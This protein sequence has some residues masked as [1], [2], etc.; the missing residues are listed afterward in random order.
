[1]DIKAESI[2]SYAVF[3]KDN[4]TCRMCSTKVQKVNIYANDA[5]ELDHIIPISKGGTHTL[6]NVQT[7]CRQCNQ[8]KSDKMPDDLDLINYIK[9][10]KNKEI[11]GIPNFQ[12]ILI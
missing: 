5:A 2:N 10:L 6:D 8:F 11:R 4:W 7:L 9:R 3:K 12:K 1:M